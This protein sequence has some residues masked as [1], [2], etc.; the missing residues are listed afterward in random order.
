M[1]DFSQRTLKKRVEKIPEILEER[2]RGKTAFL[3]RDKLIVINKPPDDKKKNRNTRDKE[4][5]VFIQG[6]RKSKRSKSNKFIKK[7]AF[8]YFI[9]TVTIFCSNFLYQI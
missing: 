9:C 2:K 4:N 7:T 5:D 1:N 6:H 3:V 8:F